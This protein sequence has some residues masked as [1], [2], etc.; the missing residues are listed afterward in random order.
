M[1]SNR[2]TDFLVLGL[3]V[4]GGAFYAS[5]RENPAAT[6]TPVPSAPV[7]AVNGFPDKAIPFRLAR[8]DGSEFA[9]QGQGPVVITLTAVT[10]GGC[11]QRIPLDKELLALAR[12]HK[13]PLY[14]V[15]VYAA[16]P[17]YGQS[18]V[19]QFQP[20]A[21]EILIDPGG[22][23]FVNQYRGSDSNCWMLIGPKGEFLYRGP[24]NMQAMRTGLQ[25]IQK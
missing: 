22:L 24:E 6:P 16:D 14:N 15:L 3:I 17:A 5:R 9:Y 18:F 11:Q 7:R 12:E 2:F 10:C 4:A 1:R 8:P 23:V 13:V 19:A 20:A 21:D 25:G